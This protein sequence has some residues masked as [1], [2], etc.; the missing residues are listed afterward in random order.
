MGLVLRLE[1]CREIMAHLSVPRPR[2]AGE[3]YLPVV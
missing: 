1:A 2:P 3:D